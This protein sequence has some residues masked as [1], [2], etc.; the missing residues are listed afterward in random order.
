MPNISKCG[1]MIVDNCSK[2]IFLISQILESYY[3]DI[4]EFKGTIPENFAKLMP[5]LRKF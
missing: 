2:L 4:N 1:D 3:I 5:N